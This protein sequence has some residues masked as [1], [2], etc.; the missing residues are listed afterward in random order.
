MTTLGSFP[1]DGE[2][3]VALTTQYAAGGLAVELLAEDGEPYAR[4]S[5]N[6]EGLTLPAH[7]FAVK[8]WSENE[9]ISKAA[10][11]SGLF[12]DTGGRVSTGFVTAEIWELA[13]LRPARLL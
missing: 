8:T 7:Q 6:L 10:R 2:T 13:H 12:S 1:F 3:I 11:R 4:L 5:V 9:E